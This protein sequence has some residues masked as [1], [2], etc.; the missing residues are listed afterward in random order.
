M[1]LAA[2]LSDIC[3]WISQGEKC[4]ILLLAH[5]TEGYYIF[6]I[7]AVCTNQKQHRKT[8]PKLNYSSKVL[9]PHISSDNSS[10]HFQARFA[11]N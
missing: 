8:L 3:A 6:F 1:D 9:S 2:S 10:F 11:N 4:N 7:F 5:R